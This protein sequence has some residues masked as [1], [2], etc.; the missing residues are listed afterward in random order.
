MKMSGLTSTPPRLPL[1]RSHLIDLCPPLSALRAHFGP[2]EEHAERDMALACVRARQAWV[3]RT[4]GEVAR[5]TGRL[6]TQGA[7]LGWP[8]PGRES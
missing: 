2:P 8:L 6:I 3:E 7:F 4:E 1:Y 5:R